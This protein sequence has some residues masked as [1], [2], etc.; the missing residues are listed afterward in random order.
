MSLV[1]TRK[2]YGRSNPCITLVEV[3]SNAE[4]G[5]P[6]FPTGFLHRK[7]GCIYHNISIY[8]VVQG[9]AATAVLASAINIGGGFTITSRMLNM[10]R[11]PTDPAEYNYLY[12]VPGAA[13]VGSYAAGHLAGWRRH[14]LPV[15]R[16]H[17]YNHAHRLCLFCICA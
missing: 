5:V 1:A 6:L 13:L 3:R 10:F 16:G 4:K 2:E 8:L 17:A 12:A 14:Y 15:S 7:E 9:L 11:R